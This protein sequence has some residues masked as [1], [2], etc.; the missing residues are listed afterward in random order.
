MTRQLMPMRYRFFFAFLLGTLNAFLPSTIAYAQDTRFNGDG[1][2]SEAGCPPRL[3]GVYYAADRQLTFWGVGNFSMVTGG[4]YAYSFVGTTNDGLWKVT[5]NYYIIPAQCR[6][7]W[8]AWTW[9]IP[10]E[11]VTLHN[12]NIIKNVEDVGG[13]C[14]PTMVTY[15]PYSNE[16][17]CP[18]PSGGGD[19]SGWTGSG[20]YYEPGQTTGGETVNWNTGQGN[21]GSSVCGLDAVVE[22]ICIEQFN[23]ETQQWDGY[24][25]GYA[26]MC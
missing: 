1:T 11:I 24:S 14:D 19:A 22:Y 10:N 25:C 21:G 8:W 6:I 7:A 18:E 4:D 9:G 17:E 26:T 3:N 2:S 23:E 20:T 13:G 15:D 12:R 5:G 16:E